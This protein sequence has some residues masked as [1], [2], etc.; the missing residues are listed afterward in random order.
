[1]GCGAREEYDAAQGKAGAGAA[2]PSYLISSV[3]VWMDRC[4]QEKTFNFLSTQLFVPKKSL[5]H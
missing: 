2:S 4:G 5:L 3:I 1:V